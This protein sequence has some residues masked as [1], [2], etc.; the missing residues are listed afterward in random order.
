MGKGRKIA[1]CTAG[2]LAGLAVAGAVGWFA[3]LGSDS[4]RQRVEAELTTFFGM[5][6][7]IGAIRPTGLA[8]QQMQDFTV[9]LPGKRD[10]VFSC[11]RASW[12]ARG[13]KRGAIAEIHGAT[14]T[15]GACDWNSDDYR[16]VV[17]G[18]LAHDFQSVGLEQVR[19]CDSRFIWKHNGFRLDGSAMD[20][21]FTIEPSGLALIQLTAGRLNDVDAVEPVAVSARIDPRELSL[22]E[23]IL[24]VP[25]L[26]LKALALDELLGSPV[27]Q[28]SFSGT[29]RL[30]DF[31]NTETIRF[32]GTATDIK[33]DELTTKLPGGPIVAMLDL[34]IEQATLEQRSL[35]SISFKG[36]VG[37]LQ[38]DQLLGRF[39]LPLLGGTLQVE[40]SQGNYEGGH[41]QRVE[42]A[43]QW[44][45][46][47]MA[48]LMKLIAS[49]GAATGQLT[50]R[51]NRL[52][53]ENDRIV[54]ADV[55]V[56]AQPPAGA[57][58]TI[59]R[60]VLLELLD[61]Y[62]SFRPPT[63]ML[64]ERVEYTQ[65]GFKLLIEGDEAIISAVPGPA[66]PAIITVKA[67]G[68]ELPLLGTLHRKI[69]LDE[70]FKDGGSGMPFGP[71]LDAIPPVRP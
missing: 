13:G 65:L 36:S 8:A 68:R 28:G 26:S 66:G 37:E 23:L 48:A 40:V 29:I 33:L 35:S 45:D 25:A 42:L 19:F 62:V 54:A 60:A 70:L 67:L 6:T 5:P 64:P 49:D 14:W 12:D 63:A 52:L 18:S 61:R 32:A 58:G 41:F 53:I 9:W 50:A 71:R 10:R 51:I 55:D 43:G 1:I 4:Y 39:G 24:K 34:E 69:K 7:E 30:S 27:S 59:D 3:Y 20:G 47:S 15:I 56:S 31:P 2:A 22:P 11:D 44:K 16:T 57:A 46:G 38:V 21:T 17:E